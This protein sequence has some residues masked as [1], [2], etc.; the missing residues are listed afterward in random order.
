MP[1]L[2]H[3]YYLS[4]FFSPGA[5]LEELAVP[6]IARICILEARSSRTTGQDAGSHAACRN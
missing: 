3:P 2:V 5:Q 6:E 1:R 4:P